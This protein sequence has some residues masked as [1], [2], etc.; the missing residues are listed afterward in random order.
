MDPEERAVSPAHKAFAPP[1]T[2]IRGIMSM[3]AR[4]AAI[5]GHTAPAG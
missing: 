4:L 1:P 5:D 3:A 2:L